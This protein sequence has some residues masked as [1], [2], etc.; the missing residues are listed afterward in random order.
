MRLVNEGRTPVGYERDRVV[1]SATPARGPKIYRDQLNMSVT[2]TEIRGKRSIAI[3]DLESVRLKGVGE[4]ALY[5][6]VPLPISKSGKLSD[7]ELGARVEI[8]LQYNRLQK[9][10]PQTGVKVALLKAEIVR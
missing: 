9:A 7:I 1:F 6:R 4:T 5:F 2:S 3:F 8:R 10:D